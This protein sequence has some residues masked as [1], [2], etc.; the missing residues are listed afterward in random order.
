MSLFVYFL[1]LGVKWLWTV[2]NTIAYQI[3]DFQWK[4]VKILN[5]RQ[6]IVWNV[7]M[8]QEFTLR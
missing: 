2:Q 4:P 8:G 3:Q 5:A 6:S 1:T 7:Q